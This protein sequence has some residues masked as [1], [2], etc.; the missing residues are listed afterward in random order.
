MQL[1]K[2]L[3]TARYAQERHLHSEAYTDIVK[4]SLTA[5]PDLRHTITY[6]N[7]TSI[8][9]ACY[10]T[11][12]M[13]LEITIA[14]C[15]LIGELLLHCVHTTTGWWNRLCERQRRAQAGRRVPRRRQRRIVKNGA[16]RAKMRT[17]RG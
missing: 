13:L 4:D 8:T 6:Q 14:L 5:I 17:Y 7:T 11:R 10:T 16:N 1:F 2:Q 12:T 9:S 3:Q 15:C